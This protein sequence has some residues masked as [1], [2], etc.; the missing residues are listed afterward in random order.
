ML[1]ATLWPGEQRGASSILEDLPHALA[2]SSR[3]LEIML[4]PNLLGYGHT[5]MTCVSKRI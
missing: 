4:C 2:T 5:L 3:A 1:L